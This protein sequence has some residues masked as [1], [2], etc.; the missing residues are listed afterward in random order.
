MRTGVQLEADFLGTI[1]N[2]RSVPGLRLTETVLAPGSRT[3]RHFHEHGMLGWAL[4]G[5]YTNAYGVRCQQVHSSGVMFCPPGEEHPTVSEFGSVSFAVELE[6]D[7]LRRFG[8]VS[9]PPTPTVFELGPA[10]SVMP[11]LHREFRETDTPSAIA[12]EGVVLELIAF[13]IRFQT[14]LET[15]ALIFALCVDAA[16]GA[17]SPAKRAA[18]SPDVPQPGSPRKHYNMFRICK[19]NF[20]VCNTSAAAL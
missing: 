3:P 5:A 1:L 14:H 11:R 18:K 16:L 8:E 12:I 10:S 6:A 13:A 19:R 17:P 7:W 15:R 2:R 4:D 20:S 9:L